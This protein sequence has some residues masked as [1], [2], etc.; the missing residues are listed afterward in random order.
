MKVGVGEEKRERK[1]DRERGREEERAIKKKGGEGD[2]REGR[3]RE[4]NQ[5]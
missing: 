2:E 5:W 1:E 3:K 4:V